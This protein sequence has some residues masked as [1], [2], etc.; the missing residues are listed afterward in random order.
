MVSNGGCVRKKSY[1][2]TYRNIAGYGRPKYDID[3]EANA[4]EETDDAT[5]WKQLVTD[6]QKALNAEFDANLPANGVA[7]KSL[8]LST[9]TL[10]ARIRS[11]RPKTV[12][13]L[14]ALLTH[15]GYKCLVD[16]DFYSGTEKMVKLFQ[17]EQVGLANPDGEF[18]AKKKSWKVL[19]KL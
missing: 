13:A 2:L 5:A 19:L 9:P 15:W 7:D 1:G 17:K 11:T 6:L 16:G 18:T 12:K 8:L 3:P 14:Q 4:V 10:N